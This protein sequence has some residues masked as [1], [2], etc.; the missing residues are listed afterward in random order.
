MSQRL[1]QQFA[2]FIVS[3]DA[4]EVGTDMILGI[5]ITLTMS[6]FDMDLSSVF[7]IPLVAIFFG[8]LTTGFPGKVSCRIIGVL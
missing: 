3:V 7:L 6:V 1:L 2:G 8:G 5:G 4:V